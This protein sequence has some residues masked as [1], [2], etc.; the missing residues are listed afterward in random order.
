MA[1]RT[2]DHYYDVV[3]KPSFPVPTAN[4]YSVDFTNKKAYRGGTAGS[5]TWT[6][7]TDPKILASWFP[8]T[9]A[10][11]TITVGNV[12]TLAPGSAA[13]V[14]NRGTATAA[15]FDFGIPQG[16]KGDKGD[17][18]SGGGSWPW[19]MVTPHLYNTLNQI[20]VLGSNSTQTVA[21]A[22]INPFAYSGISIAAT[23]G[24]D[25][26]NL[27]Y[28][29]YLS[30]TTKR[31]I[32]LG[33]TFKIAKDVII[34]WD[35]YALNIDGQ[36]AWIETTATV[37][38]VFNRQD[39]T[40]STWAYM[41]SNT[42]WNV[43]NLNFRLTG[44]Q[45]GIDTQM[46]NNSSFYNLKFISGSLG[47]KA[48][49]C[50]ETRFEKINLGEIVGGISLD[51]AEYTGGGTVGTGSV[52]NTFRDIHYA[53]AQGNGQYAIKLRACESTYIENVIVEG[54]HQAKGVWADGCNDGNF[55]L[56]MM[57]NIYAEDCHTSGAGGACTTIGQGE[58]L[59]YIRNWSSGN[60]SIDGIKGLYP[61]MLTDIGTSGYLIVNISKIVWWPQINNK[62]FYTDPASL[63]LR[64]K[65]Y[66]I[67]HDYILTQQTPP[68]PTLPIT[69]QF[70]G[71]SITEWWKTGVNQYQPINTVVV[72]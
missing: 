52:K 69:N 60:I 49:F 17:P 6:E 63:G 45:T 35:H 13:T 38:T 2:K 41:I 66:D 57:K 50:I 71:K 62:L 27:Q 15:I 30:K 42:K 68:L 36:D 9:A 23:D 40:A 5:T 18:G 14:V 28:A 21:Q 19:Q 70:A 59:V 44:S 12:T 11:S 47:I 67:S 1:Q 34:D 10:S 39:A 33:G 26:A 20:W 32:Y 25:W 46:Q 31:K 4:A 61:Q 29:I 55:R 56:L 3:G 16:F 7:V 58:A 65:L 22:G 24:Y 37:N 64:Y 48:N 54:A 51:N 72:Y 53:N 43:E 8:P